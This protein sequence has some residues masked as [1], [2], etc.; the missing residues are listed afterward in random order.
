MFGSFLL[1]INNYCWSEHALRWLGRES[2]C[3]KLLSS[4]LSS[5][6]VIRGCLCDNLKH[7]FLPLLTF[8]WRTFS[9]GVTARCWRQSAKNQVRTNQNSRNRQC[10]IVR[11]TI[12]QIIQIRWCG[13]S[14]M[15][16]ILRIA[17]CLRSFYVN[18]AQK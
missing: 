8:D 5:V 1:F 17:T 4:W 18:F 6:S 12:C 11:R 13:S 7:S 14:S 9:R 10:L 15:C 3:V 2:L 16:A